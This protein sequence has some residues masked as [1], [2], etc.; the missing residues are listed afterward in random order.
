MRTLL[1][2]VLCLLQTGIFAQSNTGALSPRLAQLPADAKVEAYVF[3]R[4]RANLSALRQAFRND[5]VPVQLR[6]SRVKQAL[7][8]VAQSSQQQLRTHLR[9]AGLQH[10][11]EIKGQHHLINM[12]HVSARAEALQQLAFA[13]DVEYI[14]LASVFRL[15]YEAPVSKIADASRSVGGHEQGLEAIHAPFMWNLGYTGLGRRLYTVDTGVWPIHPALRNQWRGN[16][17]PQEQCWVGFDFPNPADKPDAHGTHVTG[18]VLGSI[19]ALP[20]PLE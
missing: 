13:P 18:T 5:A 15:H 20:I 9:E 6:P 4:D 7:E 14:E 3:L 2:G 11:I 16:F 8:A 19:A 10:E 1:L 17:Y 12:L